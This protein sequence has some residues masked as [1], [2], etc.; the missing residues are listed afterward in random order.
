M[1]YNTLK[2][3]ILSCLTYGLFFNYVQATNSSMDIL[4]EKY[5]SLGAQ[6]PDIKQGKAL[7]NKSFKHNTAPVT[8]SCA[9]CHTKDLRSSGKHVKTNKT[10]KPMSPVVHPERLTDTKKIEKWFKRNCKWTMSRE[11]TVQEKSDFLVYINN[12]MNF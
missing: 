8:R 10:I 6:T 1:K 11:C 9:S 12:T 3:I 5:K 2:T 7:W 4:L